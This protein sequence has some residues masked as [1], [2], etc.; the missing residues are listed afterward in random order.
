MNDGDEMPAH[1]QCQ[2]GQAHG[3]RLPLPQ[4]TKLE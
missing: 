2:S 4:I 1:T 3:G